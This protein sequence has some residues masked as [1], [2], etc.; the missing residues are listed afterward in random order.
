GP[1]G[2]GR[3]RAARR[4]G[5]LRA[6]RAGRVL[7]GAD[8]GAVLDP[9]GGGDGLVDRL[10]DLTQ[11]D[12]G[13]PRGRAGPAAARRGG[14]RAVARDRGAAGRGAGAGRRLLVSGDGGPGPGRYAGGP[15]P[16]RRGAPA[17]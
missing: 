5:R 9:G 8:N 15:V 2:G 7:L 10:A 16:A 14:R 4:R 13:D 17:G 3:V 11:Q 6:E 12:G 1:S